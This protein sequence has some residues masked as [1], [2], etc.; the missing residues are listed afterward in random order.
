M[1]MTIVSSVLTFFLKEI[2]QPT[3]ILPRVCVRHVDIVIVAE[4]N[5]LSV[6][7]KTDRL[8]YN[9]LHQKEWMNLLKMFS[10]MTVRHGFIRCNIVEF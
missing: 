6:G 4:N 3:L 5:F 8:L 9:S 7:T 1:R 10:E 2:Y